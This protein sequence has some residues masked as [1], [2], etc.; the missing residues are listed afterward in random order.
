M[1]QGDRTVPFS[2]LVIR[3]FPPLA[4]MRRKYRALGSDIVDLRGKVSDIESR[5]SA[6]ETTIRQSR[7]FDI[8]QADIQLACAKYLR[9]LL[10]EVTVTDSELIISGWALPYAQP[11]EAFQFLL[12]GR[13][14]T[15]VDWPLP[16]PD[17]S[18]VLTYIPSAERCRFV[19]HQPLIS[20]DDIFIDGY[21]QFDLVS[22]QG[23]H[24]RSYRHAW[25]YPDPRGALPMPEGHQISRVIGSPDR[26]S[27]LRGGA[28]IAQR[29]KAYLY[30]RFGR[31]FRDF[32]QIF[33][34]GCGSGRVTRH[35]VRTRGPVVVGGDI[36][37]D[38][39]SWCS[40]NLAPGEFHQLPLRPPTSFADGQFD[41]VIG[42]SVFTHLLED[43]QFAWLHELQRITCTGAIVLASI[44]GATMLALYQ[45]PT[46]LY[47]AM[48]H[49]GFYV[50]GQDHSLDG[51]IEEA[52]YYQSVIQSRDYIYSKWS[53]YF[54]VIDIIDAMA[55]NQDLVVLRRR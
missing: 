45:G 30:D 11:L 17:V 36:D 16:S 9:W 37:A 21:A 34:W 52:D 1:R 3:V 54:E 53:R 31:S 28:T 20:L 33:D 51:V 10:D 14:F 29:Y 18:R 43:V 12:N 23:D 50:Y 6:A 7:S 22:A 39:I 38:N 32:S 44:Q 24:S 40:R 47:L 8:V 41:L 4:A 49:L 5:I 42:T 27:Y 15:E 35:L 55:G 19:C 48:E 26:E 13:P 2:D 46:E 25:Y